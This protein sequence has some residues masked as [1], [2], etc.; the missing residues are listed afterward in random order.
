LRAQTEGGRLL[1]L[2]GIFTGGRQPVFRVE[3]RSDGVFEPAQL[4]GALDQSLGVETPGEDLLEMAQSHQP[5]VE[6]EAA[7]L[8]GQVDRKDNDGLSGLGVQALGTLSDE[9]VLEA[10][11]FIPLPGFP[12]LY[13]RDLRRFGISWAIVV[14]SSVLAAYWL[15][16]A[17]F[18]PGQA[19]FLTSAIYYAVTV[20]TSRY[21]LEDAAST[22]E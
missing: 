5:V 12:S 19:V 9:A 22:A 2:C 18:R 8:N 15:R 20:A 10:L 14:P 16:G 11:A 17:G 21:L 13:Q 7:S 4:L 6:G 1:V 3:V